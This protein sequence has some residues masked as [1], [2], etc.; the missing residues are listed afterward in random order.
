MGGGE[1]DIEYLECRALGW[2]GVGHNPTLGVQGR[3]HW[4]DDNSVGT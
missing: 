2:V 1:V 3:P 4:E